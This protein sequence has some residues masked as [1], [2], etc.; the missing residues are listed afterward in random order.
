MYL[1]KVLRIKDEQKLR[2]Y[3]P[4]RYYYSLAAQVEVSLVCSKIQYIKKA[5]LTSV[6]KA[7]F[8]APEHQMRVNKKSK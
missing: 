3:P 2:T 6:R 4:T 1:C 8:I 5:F 7:F